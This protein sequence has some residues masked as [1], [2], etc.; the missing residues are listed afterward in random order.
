[1][2]HGNFVRPFLSSNLFIIFMGMYVV[3]EYVRV[4]HGCTV[5]GI[6]MRAFASHPQGQGIRTVVR[7]PV[8]AGNQT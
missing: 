6:H 4:A 1:M 5:C 2:P 8:C 7:S 3:S